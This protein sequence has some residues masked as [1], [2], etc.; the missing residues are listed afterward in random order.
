LTAL[1]C[2]CAAAVVFA[3]SAP[4][5][6]AA[7][8]AT[9]AGVAI[10]GHA[11]IV[12]SGARIVGSVAASTPM[13]VTVTLQPRDPLALQTFA[14]QV[15]TPG[16]P[17]FRAYITPAEFA[18]RFGATPTQIR[19]VQA[20]L[21]AHGLNPGTISANG[22]SIP[23]TASAGT[24]ARAF[25]VS[26]AHVALQNGAK[27][28]VNEQAPALNADVASDV[29][30]VLGL[31]TLSQAKPLL[32]RPHAA[33]APQLR[34]HVVTGG[35][36]PCPPA[37]GTAGSMG[38]LTADEIAAAYGLSGLYA[39]GDLGAGQTI[40]V[41]ELEPYDPADI[42]AYQQ[43]YG[44]SAQI[45]NIAVDGGAGAGE[46][47][48]EA[49]LD[50]E[51]VIG[52]APKANVAVYE[53]PN[54]GSGP[55]DTFNAIISQ[56]L[57]QVVTA[58]WGQ[59]E[60]INGSAEASAENTL[61]QEAAAQGQSILSA[62]GDDGAE[63]CFPTPPTAQVD[64]PASQPYV[65]GVGGTR[66]DALGPRPTERVWN[67]LYPT[68]AS[69]GG[70]STLW[71]MPV[72]QAI[73]PASLHVINPGSSAATCRASSGYCRE[74]PD[75]SADAD[76]ATGYV[77]YWNGTG[78]DPTQT[79]GWQV[80]GGTSGAAPTWAALIALAN[81]SATCHGVAVGFANPGLYNAASTA[82]AG[83]FNDIITGNNDMTGVNGG[84]FAAGPGYDMATGLGSPNGTA[85]AQ[86]LCTDA[87]ALANPSAQRSTIRSSV[88]LQI[89]ADDTHGASVS[90][91]ASGLPAGL[92]INSSSG[93]ITG[94]PRR[95]GTSTVTVT[96]SDPAGTTGAVSFAW[97]IEANPTLSHVSLTQVGADRP[98]L[99]FVLAAGRD[100]PQLKTV[101]VALPRGLSFTRSRATVGVTGVGNHPLK[102]TASL[103]H[104]TLVLKLRRTSRQVH[105]TISYPGIQASGGLAGQVAAKRASQ[106]ML[107]VRATDALK[108]TTKLPAR[109]KP[110]P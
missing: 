13:H 10:L 46:G 58:S 77:I 12:P 32:V 85:L 39:S 49:A 22:L 47:A 62:S 8:G 107:T 94:R 34:P 79:A 109:V 33:A 86:A 38:G 2:V 76:P 96:V 16:S 104:G 48:G 100:A 69:G 99:S 3:L 67:D 82:Y 17:L 11:P 83:D 91:S 61:F 72:Y 42:A 64:D 54:T 108:L 71:K 41:L 26:F 105:I 98:N 29:Q 25:K 50:I 56:H 57:A 78:G 90:Y 106:V 92:S 60:F 4:A 23:V 21:K 89:L 9:S 18:Q 75:V 45:A 102:F 14:N 101:T 7:V 31:D 36:Q 55:Y 15:S 93:K 5:G 28:I 30:A 80:V 27:A 65:T 73:P 19:A 63:D 1:G 35:P 52:L 88:S 37:S 53:G 74:V 59:C 84:Q 81:A 70:V 24:L 87:I 20:S 97:T 95:L 44:T 40:A 51:N 103:Q 66:I 6:A 110:G 68:G 43:C